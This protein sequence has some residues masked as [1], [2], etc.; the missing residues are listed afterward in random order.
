[1]KVDMQLDIWPPEDIPVQQARQRWMG[2]SGVLTSFLAEFYSILDYPD[3]L[4]SCCD[5]PDIISADGNS[6]CSQI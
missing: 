5:N 6:L 4:F 3:S 2:V 1:M